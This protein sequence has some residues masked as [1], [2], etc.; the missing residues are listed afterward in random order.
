MAR[1][2]WF[3]RAAG[4]SGRDARANAERVPSDLFEQCPNRSCGIFLYRKELEKD[5][6]VC[7]KCGYHF[8][9]TAVERIN[10]L[11]DEG[12]FEAFEFNLKT[13]DPLGFP[14]YRETLERYRAKTG[15]QE[16]I[17]AGRGLVGGTNAAICVTDFSFLAGSMNSVVGET[18]AR[19]LEEAAA[20]RAPIILVSGSGG[21]ARMHEGL[22][23]LMQM[24]KTAAALERYDRAG[25][26]SIC[27]LTDYTMGGVLASWASLGDV[28]LAEPG[29]NV[30]FT[31][32][33]VAAKVQ[34]ERPPENF[35]TAEFSFEHGMIDRVTPRSQLK[36]TIARLLSISAADKVR[37]MAKR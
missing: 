25:M 21:G 10:L 34:T 35:R 22:L 19:T 12:T 17:I 32:G 29:A 33:R 36:E 11:L 2:S 7:K 14:G 26:L 15:M 31:G 5:L 23:S 27:I 16:A 3:S 13:G 20:A 30:G 6:K 1:R 24:A 28:I 37:G 4:R 9:L 18:I 8:P